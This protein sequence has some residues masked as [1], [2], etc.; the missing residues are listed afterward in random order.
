MTGRARLLIALVLVALV[1]A[2]CAYTTHIRLPDEQA[3]SS[4]ILWSDGSLLTRVHGV[5][6]RDPVKL[7]DMAKVL[8]RAVIAIE[9]ARFYEHGGFDVRGIARALRDNI[10][11]GRAA[12]GG[13]TITQ[14]YV[15]AVLLSNTKTLKRKLRE[16]V[17]A[18][19]IEDRY[20]KK[21]ILERYLNTVYFGNGA[22]GV[23]AAARTYFRL[24][25]AQVN[26]PQAAL[27]AGLIRAPNDYDPFVHPEAALARRNEVI[28][29]MQKLGK[30][31]DAEAQ[32]V[33]AAPV[34]V[35]P[36]TDETQ[37]PAPF[38][39]EKVK[40]FI[41]NDPHFG[42]T[43]A[44]RE[45]LLFQGGLK[46]ET[47]LD[48]K[49]Q[50]EADVALHGILTDPTDPPGALVAVDPATGAIKAYTSS[51]NFFDTDPLSPAY[52]YAKVDLANARDEKGNPTR[53][54]G[55]SFKPFVLATA[56]EKGIPLTKTYSGASPITLHPPGQAP[57]MLENF[58]G[59]SYGRMNLVDA[60]VDSV[61]TVY[62][63]L[64]LDAGPGN[65][66]LQ[67]IAQGIN[68]PLKGVPNI[69][70]G[71]EEVTVED[72]AAAYSVFPADGVRHPP[73]FVTRVTDPSG[74]VLFEAHPVP[75]IVLSSGTARTV[76]GV[77]QQVVQRGTGVNARIGRPVAG[78][79]GTSDFRK[80]AWFVGYTPELV[81]A[82]WVGFPDGSPMQPPRTRVHAQG[83]D[84][85]ARIWQVFA[86][87]ALENVT[88]TLF[89]VPEAASSSTSSSTSTTTRVPIGPGIYS[90]I[91]LDVITATK[92][93][94]DDGYQVV[95]VRAP[96]RR[97][98]PNYVTA[99]NPPEGTAVRPGS[100]ITLTVADGRPRVVSVPNVLG[101]L[102][103][104]AAFAIR[105][106][107]LDPR[108]VVEAQPPPTS[109]DSTGKAWKQSPFSGQSVDEGTPVTVW[110]NP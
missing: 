20:S 60:T 61:N 37:Y 108:V 78:K 70:I 9:D 46:I 3:V 63:Q 96:S 76:T 97:F 27:L 13:S 53:Q 44:A 87:S 45:R 57:Y 73:V 4:R 110:V 95:I 100:T 80:N 104:Q 48:P 18:M 11:K 12:E 41:F 25:A 33:L 67:A 79:T 91:G 2:S 90:V 75:K 29:R 17:L 92:S 68:S 82:V 23:Q 50:V 84:W 36:R 58:E 59:S 101:L 69:A 38:F 56:L 16:A 102:A 54:P 47:T 15:R 14:Q 98:S 71:D 39:V 40:H 31:S 65:I 51:Q 30:I 105:Q 103:D 5:E 21:T 77:L 72:M 89:K 62:A 74:R 85:P 66:A 93:L 34:D 64:G 43:V 24:D 19:Q 7:A 83:G 109:F 107:G 35:M 26:L 86:S 55:S 106:A 99:Q 10:D 22:Y 49:W 88:P 8:P 42:P 1:G 6:D 94:T 28:T 52:S 81:A 32:L